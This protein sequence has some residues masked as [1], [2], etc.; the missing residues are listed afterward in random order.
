MNWNPFSSFADAVANVAGAVKAKWE[1]TMDKWYQARIDKE[2]A[3]KAAK[4][5]AAQIQAD[6]HAVMD[7]DAEAVAKR[8]KA[9]RALL[10][11]PLAAGLCLAVS[12]CSM[13]RQP[14]VVVPQEDV[15]VAMVHDG[16]AGYWVSKP[17]LMMYLEIADR[18]EAAKKAGKL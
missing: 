16:Q 5:T 14:I 13:F 3:A 12:G 7:D 1:L 9:H 2:E 18:Y 15:P 6:Q 11:V 4:A 10:A 8:I 17:V